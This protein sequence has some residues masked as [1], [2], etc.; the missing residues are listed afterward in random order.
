MTTERAVVKLKLSKPPPTGI[1]IYQYLQPLRK[2]EQLGSF[3]GFLRRYNNKDGVPTLEEKE[4]IIAFYHD[5]DIDMLKLGCTLTN[6]ANFC[7]H[8]STVAKFYPFTEG[9]ENL[10]EK[11]REDFV[12]GPSIV[13]TRKSIVDDNFIRKAKKKCKYMQIW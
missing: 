10:S 5:E 3:T 8:K 4:K 13:S 6:L 2:Q 11:C 9:D 1:E 7:L 12:G